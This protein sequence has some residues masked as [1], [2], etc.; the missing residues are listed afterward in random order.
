MPAKLEHWKINIPHEK[1]ND[2]KHAYFWHS[3]KYHGSNCLYWVCTQPA[4][5]ILLPISIVWGDH[6]C[7]NGFNLC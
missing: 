2:I 5:G 1:K 7:Y 3:C 6:H 4:A